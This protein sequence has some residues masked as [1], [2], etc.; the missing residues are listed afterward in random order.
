MSHNGYSE[1]AVREKVGDYVIGLQPYTQYEHQFMPNSLDY[2]LAEESLV[3]ADYFSLPGSFGRVK[4]N[5]VRV[6]SNMVKLAEGKNQLVESAKCISET[7]YDAQEIAPGVY[8]IKHSGELMLL[9]NNQSLCSVEVDNSTSRANG[10]CFPETDPLS[11][12]SM[13]EEDY[14]MISVILPTDREIKS[15]IEATF[16]SDALFKSMSNDIEV[17]YIAKSQASQHV[18]QQFKA[19]NQDLV[20]SLRNAYEEIINEETEYAQQ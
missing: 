3:V 9:S 17:A 15:N 19:N 10:H 6:S 8:N 7:C 12:F 20:L 13:C 11:E 18:V 2:L 5:L 16:G 4:P 1:N 14:I